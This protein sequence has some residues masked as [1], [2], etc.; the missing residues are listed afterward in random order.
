MKFMNHFLFLFL[1]IFLSCG[2]NIDKK[3]HSIQTDTIPEGAIQMIGFRV[4]NG[5]K[6][7]P[8]SGLLGNTFFEKF[9]VVFDFENYK[10]Y[11]KY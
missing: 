9:D 7:Y 5:G 8:Y 2:G 10:I 6:E 4:Q 3:V 11:I 1:L